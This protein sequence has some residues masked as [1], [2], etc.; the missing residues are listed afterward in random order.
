MTTSC[1]LGRNGWAVTHISQSPSWDK[2]A[3]DL[4]QCKVLFPHFLLLF[5]WLEFLAHFFLVAQTGQ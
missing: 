3:K 4:V 1:L 5:P 2:M